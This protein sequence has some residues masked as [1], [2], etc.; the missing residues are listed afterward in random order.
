MEEKLR[1]VSE[2]INKH[3]QQKTKNYGGVPK[4]NFPLQNA[5]FLQSIIFF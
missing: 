5:F 3:N 4:D 2:I 1:K